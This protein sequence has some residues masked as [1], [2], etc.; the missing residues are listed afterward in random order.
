M[1]LVAEVGHEPGARDR[2]GEAEAVEVARR[3]HGGHALEEGLRVARGAHLDADVA[4]G[5]LVARDLAV[6]DA[7]GDL[8]RLARAEQVLAALLDDLQGAGHDLVALDLPGVDVGL[9]EEAAGAPEDVEL[10]QLAVRLVRGPDELHTAAERLHLQHV[11]RLRHLSRPPRFA[12]TATLFAVVGR[13]DQPFEGS[14]ARNAI[15][16]LATPP[17]RSAWT[18]SPN[19]ATIS[20][21]RSRAMSSHAPAAPRRQYAAPQRGRQPVREGQQRVRLDRER[22]RRRLHEPAARHAPDLG[23]EGRAPRRGRRARPRSSCRRGRRRRRRRAGAR[24]RRPA[25]TAR[26]SPGAARGRRP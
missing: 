20:A 6:R 10:D 13:M 11:A 8:H 24:S 7:G 4:V 22:P 1:A 15:Q 26:G 9:H 12:L 2:L 17:R 19:R 21:R 25:R 5:R 3:A 16:L 18:G 14:I 23:R